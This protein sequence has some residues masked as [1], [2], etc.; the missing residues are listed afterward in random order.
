MKPKSDQSILPGERL[1]G[2]TD[3][4]PLPPGYAYQIDPDVTL[5]P[6]PLSGWTL[7]HVWRVIVSALEWAIGL[8]CG[9]G[10]GAVLGM[11]MAHLLYNLLGYNGAGGAGGELGGLGDWMGALM[12]G[13]ALGAACGVG[14]VAV[15]LWNRE[16]RA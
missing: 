2:L 8:L 4:S 13:G 12:A 14:I 10:T 3:A 15:L 9:A 5:T 11:A 7:G 1:G 6:D 16:D